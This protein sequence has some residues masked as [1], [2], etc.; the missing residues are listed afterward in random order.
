MDS[1]LPEIKQSLKQH[2]KQ[3]LTLRKQ[4]KAQQA[5]IQQLQNT[6]A[7]LSHTV[8]MLEQRTGQK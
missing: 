3:I 6:I 2:D 4:L 1:F 8:R 5:M 7:Q